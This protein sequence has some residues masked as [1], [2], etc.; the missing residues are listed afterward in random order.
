METATLE[1]LKFIVLTYLT[2]ETATEIINAPKVD[3]ILDGLFGCGQGG[4]IL[5][6]VFEVMGCYL[7]KVEAKWPA[8]CIYHGY[9]YGKRTIP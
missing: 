4:P 8:D 3:V 7:E 2:K 6:T 5:R 1:K 9:A